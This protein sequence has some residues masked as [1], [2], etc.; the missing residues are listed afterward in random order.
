MS[1]DGITL[2]GIVH[3]LQQ[4]LL[5]SKI[6]RIYQPNQNEIV[7]F[8]L[9]NRKE[10]KLIM[11]VD[12][13]N[14]RIHLVDTI[15]QNPS[16][17]PM[18][19]MLLRKYLL[20]GKIHSIIQKGLERIVEIA[21][22]NTDEF[23][24]YKEYK[25]IVETMGKHSNIILTDCQNI[26]I[27]SVKRISSEVN[28]YR[29]ILPGKIYLEPPLEGKINLISVNDDFIISTLK[30]ASFSQPTKTLSRWIIDN[31]AGFSGTSA[32]EI[33]LR[34]QVDHKL[35]ICQLNN[36]HIEQIVQ[37][38]SMLREGLLKHSFQ[39]YIYFD[40]NTKVPIDFWVFSMKLYDKVLSE[41][42][43]SVNEA[44]DLF[45]KKKLEF[46]TVKTLKY[47]LKSQVQKHIK[48]LKLNL[49]HLKER[50]NKTSDLSKYKLWGELLSANLYRIK[51]GQKQVILPN[52]YNSNEEII[53]PLN[54]KLSPSHNAQLY[55]KMYKK[56]R[57][58]EK[59]VE[60]RI[61][62]TLMELDY[63]E[64]ILVNIEHSQTR[65]DLLEI[66][67]ELESQN[68]IRTNISNR[69]SE[70]KSEI[71][72][73]L[74]FKSSDGTFIYVGKNNRQNDIL[75][76]KKAKPDDIWLH[77]KNTPGSH[78]II[79]TQGK[80]VSDTTLTEAA[81]LAAYYSNGRNSSN[82]PVDYTFVRHVKKPSGA[83]PGFVIYYNQKTLYVTPDDNIINKLSF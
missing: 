47:D 2:Y 75:T 82:V 26:I 80:D 54:E 22:T 36:Q 81:I 76:F 6:S 43:Y 10:H 31:F 34:A 23:M 12:P 67:H 49:S 5:E 24:Q 61:K 69:K 40:Y 9:H 48:K 83:K 13:M 16:S 14:C 19:C 11:S 32:Q 28:R 58:T 30:E 50:L 62:K 25:L 38:F 70:H 15:Q 33:A 21:V 1:F 20:G 29:E 44:A 18:F 52:F 77:A 8:L 4:S 78:V 37:A 45:F 60:A 73:P 42:L 71:S 65:G 57:T 3:E 53:I 64:S 27:D 72:K 79:E 46:L 35:P 17:P 51:A 63:L 7:L 41:S 56:L 66:Q 74:Q 39:P 55:F 68:Y 59:N